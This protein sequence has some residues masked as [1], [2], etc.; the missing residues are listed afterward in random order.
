MVL[1]RLKLH[2]SGFNLKGALRRL[3]TAEYSSS[4]E[5]YFV[6]LAMERRRQI[7]GD[8]AIR[9]GVIYNI[10]VPLSSQFVAAPEIRPLVT[11]FHLSLLAF[12]LPMFLPFLSLKG[13]APPLFKGLVY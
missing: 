4:D 6:D 7:A 9:L 1:N 3:F 5:K 2:G 12:T 10:I 11:L 8:I 13:A